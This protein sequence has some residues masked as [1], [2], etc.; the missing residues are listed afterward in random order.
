MNRR[1]LLATLLNGAWVGL[2]CVTGFQLVSWV[3]SRVRRQL[4][5]VE[6]LSINELSTQSEGVIL[7]R[8]DRQIYVR[9]EEHGIHALDMRCTHGNCTVRYDAGLKRFYCPCHG[10]VFDREGNVLAGP[11]TERLRKLNVRMEHDR[12][13]MLDES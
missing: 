13:Y 5:K 11:P 1:Q 12:I 9:Q 6:L 3:N 4:R 10:G 7:I 2:L 8:G